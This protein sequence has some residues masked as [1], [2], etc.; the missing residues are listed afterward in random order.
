M[1]G[2][3]DKIAPASSVPLVKQAAMVIEGGWNQ[4]TKEIWLYVE[5]RSSLRRTFLSEEQSYFPPS[6][7]LLWES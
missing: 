4:E 5:A 6:K 3:L 1:S 7:A 2:P